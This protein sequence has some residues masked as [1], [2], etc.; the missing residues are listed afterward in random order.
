MNQQ[1]IS[2]WGVTVIALFCQ[3]AMFRMAPKNHFYHYYLT[4]IL[5]LLATAVLAH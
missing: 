2:I 4:I 5:V 1:I 3:W